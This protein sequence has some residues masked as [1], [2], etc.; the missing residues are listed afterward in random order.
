MA[1]INIMEQIVE[2]KLDILL[3]GVDCCKCEYCH[4]DMLAFALNLVKP[5]YV[6]SAR[7]ELFGRIDS[8]KLQNSVDINIAVAKAIEVVSS[9]P[10]HEKTTATTSAK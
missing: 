1:V 4:Q 10:N 6:N 9:S 3:S 8:A 7:G 2:E 5:K